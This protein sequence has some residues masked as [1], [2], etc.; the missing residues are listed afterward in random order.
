MIAPAWSRAVKVK[1][2]LVRSAW[3]ATVFLGYVTDEERVL[4]LAERDGPIATGKTSVKRQLAL[5]L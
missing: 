5:L 4:F 3:L 2:A 1:A